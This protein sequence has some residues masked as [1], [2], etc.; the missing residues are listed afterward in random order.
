MFKPLNSLKHWIK[1]QQFRL[2]LW[3][4]GACDEGRSSVKGM[5][6]EEAYAASDRNNLHWAMVMSG[7]YALASMVFKPNDFPKFKQALGFPTEAKDRLY[8][9][10][11]ARRKFLQDNKLV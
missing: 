4:N 9:P 5:T 7:Y 8:A 3:L 11:G 2:W 10:L 1:V 6:A